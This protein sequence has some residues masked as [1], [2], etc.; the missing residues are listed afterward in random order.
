MMA[1]LSSL[2]TLVATMQVATAQQCKEYQFNTPFV[3]GTSCEDIYN[4]N[5]QSRNASGYYWILDGPTRVY[6]GMNYTGVS[7]EDIYLSNEAIRDKSGYYRIISNNSWVF[8][9]MIAIGIS[10]DFSL[11]CGGVDGIWKRIANLDVGAGDDCPSPWVK[12]SYN[13]ASYCLPASSGG[14]CYSVFYSTNGISYQTVCARGSVFPKDSLD[15]IKNLG[16]NDL[17][18]D[19]LSIT[20]GNPREHIWTYA[21]SHGNWNCANPP[22]FVGSHWTIR[23]ECL[24]CYTYTCIII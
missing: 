21:F 23:C 15:G 10:G 5:L 7:C 4:K 18:V 3:P 19:G 11:S 20:R 1:K 9:D 22:T 16:I 13:G 8:C 12:G 2:L 6:C 24:S 14:G 17:Y